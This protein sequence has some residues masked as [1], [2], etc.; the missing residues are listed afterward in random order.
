MVGVLVGAAIG[1]GL[2]WTNR[3]DAPPPLRVDD[4]AGA[5]EAGAS[6]VDLD[7]TWRVV[8]GEDTLAGLRIEEERAAVLG[9]NTAVGRTGDVAGSLVVSA[10]RVTRGSVDVDLSGIEFTDDPGLPVAN[11]SEYLRTH[12]IETDRF[13][14]ARFVLAEPVVL[15]IDAGRTL[16]KVP[17]AGELE[18]H[19]VQRPLT[20]RVDVRISEDRVVIGTTRPVTVRL[21]SFGIEPPE[22]PRLSRVADEGSFELVAVLSRR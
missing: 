19:G 2:W 9:N 12:A 10:G 16:R 11:R 3:S 15:P 13:P 7:G 5:A 14:R 17:V 18:L 22:I 21:R 4:V 6:A 20:I 1:V 8:V